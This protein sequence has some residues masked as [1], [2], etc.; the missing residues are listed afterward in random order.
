MDCKFKIEK[1]PNGGSGNYDGVKVSLLDVYGVES[2]TLIHHEL[3][4]FFQAKILGR[5]NQYKL[6]QWFTE[7]MAVAYSGQNIVPR[8]KY[9]YGLKEE[10]E[11]LG[12]FSDYIFMDEYQ[13]VDFTIAP[14]DALYG[15]WGA[16]FIYTICSS[17]KINIGYDK[18]MGPHL[19]NREYELSAHILSKAF[20]NGFENKLLD[21][22]H[23]G[24]LTKDSVWEK[25]EKFLL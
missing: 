3:V 24:V 7:G 17:S 16:M 25:L 12:N 15:I 13:E 6:P 10:F 22:S 2:E 4:H 14:Y 23:N 8:G 5:E 21:S 20:E 1:G 18:D 9:I 19:S 11:A